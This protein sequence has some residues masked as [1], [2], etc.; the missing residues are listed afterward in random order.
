MNLNKSLFQRSHW[1]FLFYLLLALFVFLPGYMFSYDLFEFKGVHL[2]AVTMTLWCMMLIGQPLLIK[3]KK[4]EYHAFLGKV[5]YLLVPLMVFSSLWFAHFAANRS[6]ILNPSGLVYTTL[7]ISIN[8]FFLMVYALAIYHR[9]DPLKHARYMAS[10]VLFLIVP[11]T[12][13]LTGRLFYMFGSEESW[14]TF[15]E[16][17]PI[18]MENPF[19]PIVGFILADAILL[20]LMYKDWK[21]NRRWKEFTTVFIILNLYHLSVMILPAIPVWQNFLY[22]FKDLP[23]P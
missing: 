20:I 18:I 11:V 4:R 9:S 15:Y 23:M 21:S 7:P 5:S 6:D 3:F 8:F 12:D 10:T 1:Y 17:L 13:R 19:L 2:H 16:A 14:N 22:W